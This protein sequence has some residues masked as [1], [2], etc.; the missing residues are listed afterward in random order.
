MKTKRK[1]EKNEKKVEKEKVE[2]EKVQKEKKKKRKKAGELSRM[3]RINPGGFPFYF[4]KT[5]CASSI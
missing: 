3:I 2:K 4:L 1:K 5:P